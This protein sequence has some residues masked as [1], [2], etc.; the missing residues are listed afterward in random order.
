MA[1]KKTTRKKTAGRAPTLD[2]S[3]RICVLHGSD[4]YLRSL[5]TDALREALAAAHGEVE[6]FRFDGAAAS[7]AEVLD[8]CRS[9]GLMQQAKMVVVDHADQLVK[10][11]ARPLFER[12]AEAPS[13]HATLVLRCQRWNKGKLDKG[14]ERCGAIVRCEIDSPEQAA[15]WAVGRARKRHE[16]TLED[17]ASTLLV[18]RIGAT[19]GRLDAEIQKLAS[20]ALAQGERTITRDLVEEMVEPTAEEQAW[21][22]QDAVVTGDPERAVGVIRQALGQWRCDPTP[23]CWALVDLGRK[24]HAAAALSERGAPPFEIAKAVKIWGPTRDATLRL[25]AGAGRR[26]CAEV[27]DAAVATDRALKSGA[28]D[29]QRALETLA[30]RFASLAGRPDDTPRRRRSRP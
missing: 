10:E 3:T 23:V 11:D 17:P 8:E 22:V 6:V 18:E 25:A 12:Y 7:P 21:R 20:A 4:D 1:K 15:M 28:P 2:A 9:M 14:V 27:F 29:A 19:L 30:C 13:E 5:R 26:R 24:L 16:V